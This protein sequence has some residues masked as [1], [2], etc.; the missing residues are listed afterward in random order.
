MLEN[1]KKFL[2]VK[3]RG[4]YTPNS[5]WPTQ[6]LTHISET[7]RLFLVG[8]C[9]DG[10]SGILRGSNHGPTFIRKYLDKYMPASFYK[11]LGDLKVIP[12][13]L[14]DELLNSETILK[15]QDFLYVEKGKELPVS[16]LSVA[17]IFS[18]ELYSS[19]KDA[20]LLALGGDHSISYP[21]INSF[22][23][24]HNSLGKR[25]AVI[26]FDAH[27]DLL[28]SRQGLPITFGSW[29]SQTLKIMPNKKNFVQIGVRD[30][31]KE[32]REW[33]N[34]FGIQQFWTKEVEDRGVANITKEILG[35]IEADI[36]YITIDI[37]VL[38]IE[39]APAT[40]TPVEKGLTPDQVSSII[41]NLTRA[42]P[43]GSADLVEVAPLVKTD[44]HTL[45]QE[46]T[47]LSSVAILTTLLEVMNE[48]S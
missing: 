42:V 47:L 11:D 6:D 48:P 30:S 14:T 19:M 8:V 40:G 23:S 16:P 5:S 35:N 31:G 27:T 18:K 36:L 44:T 45:G 3:N 29:A 43:L 22:L 25:V 20:K 4:I 2:T 38:D 15:C 34:R 17:S 1:L 24:H 32:K 39:Y 26:H 12:H 46:T 33:V 41:L 13:L 21:L 9:F 37:D 10:G 7:D 28:E